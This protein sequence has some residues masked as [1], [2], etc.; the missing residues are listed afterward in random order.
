MLTCQN[1]LQTAINSDNLSLNEGHW[2]SAKLS[3]TWVWK[4]IQECGLP[5][6]TALMQPQHV[7]KL[8][9]QNV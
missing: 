2:E 4:V 8:G 1:V 6:L 9:D 3:H 7:D 5:D